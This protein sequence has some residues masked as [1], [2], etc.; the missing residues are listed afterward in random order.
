MYKDGVQLELSLVCCQVQLAKIKP[1]KGYDN[2][3]QRRSATGS[4]LMV[5]KIRLY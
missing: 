1:L 2:Y 5:C 4:G 3:I